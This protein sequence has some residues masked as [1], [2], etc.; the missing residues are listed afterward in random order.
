MARE[1]GPGSCMCAACRAWM[2][3]RFSAALV[4]IPGRDESQDQSPNYTY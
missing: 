4:N 1:L 3:E 2:S